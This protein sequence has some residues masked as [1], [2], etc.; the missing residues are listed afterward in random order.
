MVRA[1]GDPADAAAD[2]RSAVRAADP[3]ITFNRAT[4]LEAVLAEQ[5]VERRMT[6]GVIGGLA[7]AALALAAVELYGLL[8]VRGVSTILERAIRR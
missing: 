3:A 7:G 4:T 2:I 6:T 1:S 5:M 8:A